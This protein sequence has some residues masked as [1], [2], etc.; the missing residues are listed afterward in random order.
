MTRILIVDDKEQNRYMLQVLLQKSGYSVE[1]AADG[2]EALALARRN[3]PDMVVSDVLMPVMDGFNLCREWRKDPALCSLPFIFYTS[4]YSDPRD[5][6]FALKLGA[7]KYIVKPADPAGLLDTFKEVLSDHSQRKPASAYPP[8]DQREG[9]FKNYSEVLVRKLEDKLEL[10]RTIFTIDPS[11]IFLLSDAY[12]ILE[13]NRTAESPLG[14]RGKEALDRNFIDS[15][16]PEAHRPGFIEQIKTAL[17]GGTMR[18]FES[19]MRFTDDGP[20]RTLLWNAQRLMRASGAVEGVLL[21]GKDITL[22]RSAEKQRAEIENQLRQAQKMEAIGQLAG[23]VAHDFNNLLFGIVAG[24]ELI[25]KDSADPNVQAHARQI[26]DMAMKGGSLTRQ[27]LTFARKGTYVIAAVD[28]RKSVGNVINILKHSVDKRISIEERY[29]AAV[30]QVG[31]DAAQLEN[32]ILNLAINARDAM[33]KGGRL[34]FEAQTLALKEDDCTAQP[35]ECRP[36]DYVEIAVGD[37][38]IGMEKETQAHIFEPFFTT[39]GIGKGTG[40]GLSSVYG[41][42]KQMGGFLRVDSEKGR[43]S[44]FRMYLPLSG[45]RETAAPVEEQSEIVKG[46]GH[47]LLVE[48]EPALRDLGLRILRNLGY[49]TAAC[50]DGEE[51]IK[52]LRNNSEKVD[53][54]ILDLIMPRLGG[55]DCFMEIRKISPAIPVIISSGFGVDSEVQSMLDSGARGFI[56]KPYRIEAFSRLIAEKIRKR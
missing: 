23:G 46:S 27:L 21:I 50:E 41:F 19:V 55:Y 44:V 33:P 20:E 5:E 9:Y 22:R 35:Y 39:K 14:V 16:V 8:A 36:G 3:P 56:Q 47:V 7:D 29:G 38:G 42:T 37:T 34:T 24:S 48:D 4:T 31:T 17:S 13:L 51:A 15:F 40:L 32:A 43:G 30:V 45:G 26:S 54:V 12:A 18:D 1:S 25:K 10:F 2:A 28:V 6:E 49:Q 11:V 52:Y 53:L